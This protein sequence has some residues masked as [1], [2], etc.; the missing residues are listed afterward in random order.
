MKLV[1]KPLNEE[2]YFKYLGMHIIVRRFGLDLFPMKI[3]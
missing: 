3:L 1:I 2:L